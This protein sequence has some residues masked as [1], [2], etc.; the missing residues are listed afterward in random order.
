MAYGLQLWPVFLRRPVCSLSWPGQKAPCSLWP[1]S[2]RTAP[3]VPTQQPWPFQAVGSGAR[4]PLG[5]LRP[6][7]W[8]PGVRSSADHG[9]APLCLPFPRPSLPRWWQWDPWDLLLWGRHT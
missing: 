1:L 3:P 5:L 6:G 8:L 2:L 9:P 4:V 7:A